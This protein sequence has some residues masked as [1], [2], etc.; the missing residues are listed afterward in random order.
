[1]RIAGIGR[2][3][4]LF[5]LEELGKLLGPNVFLFVSSR[6]ESDIYDML[7]EMRTFKIEPTERENREGVRMYCETRL[8]LAY[9]ANWLTPSVLLQCA[10]EIEAKSTG[11]FLF[12]R[13]DLPCGLRRWLI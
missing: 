2:K 8:K 12:C 4:L 11:V 3:Q 9:T 10:E 1:M 6:P 7:K 13:V 5:I